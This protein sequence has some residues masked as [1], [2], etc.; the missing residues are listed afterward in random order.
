MCWVAATE[1]QDYLNLGDAF[2]PVVV[3]A[4]TGRPIRH[5]PCNSKIPRLSAVGTIGHALRNGTIW[6]WGTGSSSFANPLAA[7]EQ[8][9]PYS[10]PRMTR[11]DVRATRGPI[12]W[13]L[14]T[15]S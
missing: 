11:L 10:I 15:G 6:V 14:L 9:R 1:G 7:R 13:K 8:R 4:L 2:S 3:A 12:S 5:V